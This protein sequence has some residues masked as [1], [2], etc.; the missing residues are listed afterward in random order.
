MALDPLSMGCPEFR[1]TG[2]SVWKTAGR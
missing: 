1:T 2:W